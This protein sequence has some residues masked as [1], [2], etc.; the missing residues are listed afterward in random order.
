MNTDAKFNSSMDALARELGERGQSKSKMAEGV[1]PKAAAEPAPTFE[2][3]PEPEPA[4]VQ[5][6]HTPVAIAPTVEQ[7]G[8]S[9]S[10]HMSPRV[11]MQIPMSAE[12]TTLI[13]EFMVQQKDIIERMET[14]MQEQRDE[15]K[16]ERAA[17]EAKVEQLSTPAAAISQEELV[18]LQKRVESLHTDKLLSDEELY[19]IEDLI[20]DWVETQASMV[21][22][23]VTAVMLYASAVR[24]NTISHTFWPCLGKP[25]MVP[26]TLGTTIGK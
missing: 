9:H 11:P 23:T 22:Q 12:V 17:L 10:T 14:K 7:P 3:A 18:A 1:P 4:P 5:P 21:D 20:S 13:K 19:L 8:S 24:H 15:A 16:A 26:S 2:P 6:A 25:L